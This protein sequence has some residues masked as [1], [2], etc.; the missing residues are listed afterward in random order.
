[1][2]LFALVILGISFLVL[3]LTWG[4]WLVWPVRLSQHPVIGTIRILSGVAGF[5]AIGAWM[6][7]F[8]HH[9]KPPVHIT[10]SQSLYIAVNMIALLSIFLVAA[11]NICE[12]IFGVSFADT[13]R[14][15]LHTIGTFSLVS[16]VLY[17]IGPFLEVNDLYFLA[18]LSTLVL[19][20]L[21]IIWC[22]NPVRLSQHFVLGLIRVISGVAGIIAIGAW[23]FFIRHPIQVD[24]Y[25]IPPLVSLFIMNAIVPLSVLLV[26][27][28]N[29]YEPIVGTSYV[30]RLRTLLHT[31]G[32]ISG[33]SMLIYYFVH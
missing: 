8:G 33:T 31:I 29:I 13:Y 30:Y 20:I 19:P 4:I 23:I 32:I 1:M 17:Y 27:A 3:M 12:P 2:V 24:I 26:A 22:V 18:G 16:M 21:W 14:G 7:L 6:L 25:A 15:L 11:D 5:V 10:P 28:D 9:I